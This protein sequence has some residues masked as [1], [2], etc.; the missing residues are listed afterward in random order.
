MSDGYTLGALFIGCL[1][2]A[3]EMAYWYPGIKG[4]QGH[5]VSHLGDLLPFLW[6]WCIGALMVLTVGGLIGWATDW[7]VW[8]AGWLGDGALVW[9]LGAYRQQAPVALSQPL[10]QGGLFVTGIL[11]AVTLIRLKKGGM[12]GSK[13]RG[14]A[15]GML[16]ALSA[17]VA[18]FAAVP[19]VS[20]VNLAGFWATG[21][22]S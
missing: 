17:G 18:K 20:A 13:K 6:T 21:T 10:T 5:P 14:V 12:T 8:G 11:L 9:G 2:F 22:L 4:L 3:V 16:T 1:L 15:C 19:L 7:F